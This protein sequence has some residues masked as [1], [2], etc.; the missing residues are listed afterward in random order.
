MRHPRHLRLAARW[1]LRLATP[2][3]LRLA[4]RWSLR[5]ATPR[6]LRLAAGWSVR[7]AT[8]RHL[9]LTI[10]QAMMIGGVLEILAV[11]MGL[12]SSHSVEI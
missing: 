1:S 7:L 4:A 3:H 8:P 11:E 12:S 2:R 10:H 6:H 9:W 5:L